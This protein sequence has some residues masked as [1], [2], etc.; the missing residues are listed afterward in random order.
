MTE[1][2]KQ[3]KQSE[4]D[5]TELLLNIERQIAV[6]QWIQAFGVFAESILLVKLFSIKNGT[7]RNPAVISGEQKI[8]TGNWVQTIG[9]VLEAAGVTAQIDGPSIGLQRLTVTGDIIQSIGA[10][11][12]AA[13]GE[14]IIA[15]EVT[16]QAFEPFIP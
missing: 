12:Q 1:T 4:S 9:Q 5:N 11:L 3:D 15:A 8:V 14:Q 10:A 6:T 2:Q 7:S 16:Q 13:G